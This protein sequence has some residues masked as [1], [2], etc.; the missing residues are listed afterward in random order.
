M[1]LLAGAIVA[2]MP[3]ALTGA[4]AQYMEG[5]HTP[6][7]HEG[8]KVLTPGDATVTLQWSG[9]AECMSGPEVRADVATRHAPPHWEAGQACEA[10]R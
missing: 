4:L 3:S 2:G 9:A 1:N 10:R 6:S 8:R 7:R 5:K